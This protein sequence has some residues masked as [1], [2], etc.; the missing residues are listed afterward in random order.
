M[1][2]L[3]N[4]Y[5]PHELMGLPTAS[6]CRCDG[7]PPEV[8]NALPINLP[9]LEKVNKEDIPSIARAIK[10]FRRVAIQFPDE[11]LEIAPDVTH[12]LQRLVDGE[13]LGT[14]ER[15]TESPIMFILA[16]TACGSCCVDEVA[17]EHYAAG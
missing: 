14:P 15:S 13:L 7:S 9:E 16:D 4:L 12:E 2:F 3:L 6:I 1:T 11:F 5:T 8:T 10:T 17:A